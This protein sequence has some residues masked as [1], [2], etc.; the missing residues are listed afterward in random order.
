M[1][2]HISSTDLGIGI[3]KEMFVDQLHSFSSLVVDVCSGLDP[4]VAQFFEGRIRSVRVVGIRQRD[5][6]HFQ[7]F[8]RAL[9]LKT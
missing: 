8:L 1:W 6:E 5:F 2:I 7:R 3:P 9:F 4:A